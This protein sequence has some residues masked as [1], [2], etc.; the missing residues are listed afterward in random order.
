VEENPL[1]NVPTLIFSGDDD[2]RTPQEDAAK[3]AAELPNAKLVRVPATG[4]SVLGSDL[5]NCS[6]D[7]LRNFFRG[8]PP[9]VCKNEGELVPPSPVPPTSLRQLPRVHGLPARTGRTLIAARLTL[10]DLFEHAVDA[11]LFSGNG[12]T[13][14]RIG[15]LRAGY[16]AADASTLAMHGYSWV[17]G[18]TLSGKVP[19]R[20]PIKIKVGG[21]AAARGTL[22]ITERGTITGR[23]DGH[24][25][26]GRFLGAA[27]LAAAAREAG[28]SWE[29][30]L[31]RFEPFSTEVLP[32]G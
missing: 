23:L 19:L 17:P 20:G 5:S 8:L 18:V 29:Q 2:L 13:I 6:L 4:H 1:P 24:K 30:S 7:A 14:P 15:G 28:P 32:A 26:S 11:L 31:R 10:A 3:L 16:F 22:R 25:I 12:L 27:K 9:K 21:R